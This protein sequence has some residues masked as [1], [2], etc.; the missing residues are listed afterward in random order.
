[1]N[2]KTMATIVLAVLAATC[3]TACHAAKTKQVIINSE[4]QGATVFINQEV[5]GQTPV[6]KEITFDKPESQRYIII[7]KKEGYK[8]ERRYYY[9]DDNPN[10]LFQLV[11]LNGK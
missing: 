2:R 1:V 11:P 6:K 3:F 8:P 9:Y 4:P 10:I 7:I 5:V